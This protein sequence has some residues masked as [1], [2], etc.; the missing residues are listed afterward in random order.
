MRYG[1][2]KDPKYIIKGER[3][4][5]SLKTVGDPYFHPG[6]CQ[7]L[8]VCGELCRVVAQWWSSLLTASTFCVRPHSLTTKGG[9]R[10]KVGWAPHI[11]GCPGQCFG[12]FPG[13]WGCFCNFWHPFAFVFA[14]VDCQWICGGYSQRWA[15]SP[16]CFHSWI[17]GGARGWSTI[18]GVMRKGVCD[19]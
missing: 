18:V 17:W 3:S 19:V 10:F 1:T 9:V 7:I 12:R 16:G 15:V 2:G 4:R 11:R 13:G 14:H 8:T 5:S 6:S